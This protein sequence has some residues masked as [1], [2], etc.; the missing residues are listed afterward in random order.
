MVVFSILIILVVLLNYS[1]RR[2]EKFHNSKQK[3]KIQSIMSK[4][5]VHNYMWLRITKSFQKL[6]KRLPIFFSSRNIT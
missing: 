5:K 4:E 6:I 1:E 2:G 3:M